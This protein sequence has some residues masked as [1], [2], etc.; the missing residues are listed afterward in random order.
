MTHSTTQNAADFFNVISLQANTIYPS[1]LTGVAIEHSTS[2]KV[3]AAEIALLVLAAH[4][5]YEGSKGKGSFT[6]N[7]YGMT[8]C[9]EDLIDLQAFPRTLG[10]TQ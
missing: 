6:V 1:P 9:W 3:T 4:A 10:V 8:K 5:V 7:K 2:D